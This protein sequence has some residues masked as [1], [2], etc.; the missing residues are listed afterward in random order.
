[1]LVHRS[2]RRLKGSLT[3]LSTWL[4]ATSGQGCTSFTSWPP[5]MAIII[6]W[7]WSWSL[8][9][10]TTTR[11]LWT[12]F[13]LFLT[14]FVHWFVWVLLHLSLS[15]EVIPHFSWQDWLWPH[16]LALIFTSSCCADLMLQS[17]G[18]Y[19]KNNNNKNTNKKMELHL[20]SCDC[21][22]FI[23]WSCARWMQ[24]YKNESEFIKPC[25]G[26]KRYHS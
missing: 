2:P 12:L 18:L 10:E 8:C 14:V 17:F 20:G 13:S 23:M 9:S 26:F 22:V 21:H 7:R 24:L 6:V 1:M 25:W 19:H 3:W 4:D 16:F 5:W 11:D 15:Y